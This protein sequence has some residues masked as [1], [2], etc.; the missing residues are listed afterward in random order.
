M[1]LTTL[2]A[3][4]AIS[5]AAADPHQDESGHGRGKGRHGGREY[6][7]AFWDGRCKVERKSE[8]N[9]EYKEKR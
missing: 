7:E 5:P 2:P 9:G 8:K 3:A 4:G 1:A 6:K